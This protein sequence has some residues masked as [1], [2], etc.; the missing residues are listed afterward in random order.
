MTFAEPSG[1][2]YTT[3]PFTAPVR[4][5]GPATLEVVLSSSAPET[6]IWAVLSDV[7]PDGSAHPV[8]VGRL[9]NSYPDIDR[10]KS[11]LDADGDVVQPYGRY[12]VHKPAAPGEERRYFVEFFPIGNQFEAGHRLRLHLLGASMASNPTTPGLNT[13]RL[14]PSQSVLRFPVLPGSQG[15]SVLGAHAVGSAAQPAAAAP[16]TAGA[17]MLPETGPTPSEAAPLVLLVAGITVR[18]LTRKRR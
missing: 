13:V 4:S 3:A 15:A 2:S 16:T 6:D 5:A 10:G 9:R 11:L 14:G 18:R 8:A 12:D 7:W 17:T 1:L